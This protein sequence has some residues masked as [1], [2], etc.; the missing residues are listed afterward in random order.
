V[1]LQRVVIRDTREAALAREAELLEL[2]G[3][4]KDDEDRPGSAGV[5][6]DRIIAGNPDEVV[7]QLKPYV[8]AGYRHLICGFPPPYDDE[9]MRRMATEVRPALEA[10]V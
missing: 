8:D 4:A 1:E 7:E 6:S 5:D 3:G 2:N 9:T 10:L